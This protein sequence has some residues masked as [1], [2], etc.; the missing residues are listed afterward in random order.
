[1]S[2]LTVYAIQESL[3]FVQITGM[4]GTRSSMRSIPTL[5]H[6]KRRRVYRQRGSNAVLLDLGSISF[7]VP[8]MVLDDEDMYLPVRAILPL[9]I[10]EISG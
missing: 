5:R 7:M 4:G 3:S 2:N 1:M 9:V 6:M 8:F 10:V